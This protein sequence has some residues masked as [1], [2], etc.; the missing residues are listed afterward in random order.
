[1]TTVFLINTL[2]IFIMGI[3][4]L[5]LITMEMD[6]WKPRIIGLIVVIIFS[7]FFGWCSTISITEEQGVWNNGHCTECGGE[8]KFSG[9]SKYRS[10]E[11]YYYT[12]EKC[13]HTI[14]TKT[15]KK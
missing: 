3:A 2:V 10:R 5:M 7:L 1:M 6:S 13:D 9:A 15:I 4:F 12:C 8:Y 11:Y 14:E